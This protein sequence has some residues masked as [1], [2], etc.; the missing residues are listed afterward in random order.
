MSS[1]YL[2]IVLMVVSPSCTPS[3]GA[4]IPPTDTDVR[5]SVERGLAFLEKG[6][7]AW[8]KE[9]G[10][11]SCHHV[12]FLL[13]SHNEAKLRGF[14]TN[15]EKLDAWI[16]WTLVNMLARGQEDG[17]GLETL[18][19]VLLGRDRS[20]AW[21]Q[22]PPRHN[23]TVDPYETLWEFLLEKQKAD[24]SFPSEGQRGFPEDISTSWALLALASRD[25]A[26][27]PKDV[28]EGLKK[29]GLGPG[30]TAK[31]QKLDERIPQSQSRALA[32]LKSSKPDDSTQAVLLRMAVAAKLGDP[33]RAEAARKELVGRQ[34]TD[35][36]WAYQNGGEQ[37]DAFATGQALFTLS[38]GGVKPDDPVI[39]AARQFL[40]KTQ[41]PDGSWFVSSRSIHN[42][43][44][45]DEYR[46]RTDEV[47]SYWG[48]AW[49]TLGL[50]HTLPTRKE[51]V[52][53]PVQDR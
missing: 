52:V 11:A 45:G 3:Q 19:Q 5:R 27:A 16:N 30:M 14:P 40:P 15:D 48:S 41:R 44:V 9:R 21:R 17:G 22:K 28:A 6:G 47:Y 23:Q 31:L 20:S 18:T 10:C 35:G 46:K 50:L 2:A 51:D 43:K 53:V 8:M 49:A 7:V 34:K 26:K 38:M 42:E 4:D 36:G 33:D 39:A 37:S 29:Y 13:W 12:P 24:G 32:W 25:T 1:R